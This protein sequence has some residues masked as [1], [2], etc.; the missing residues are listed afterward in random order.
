MCIFRCVYDDRIIT[1]LSK[2][3]GRK[4]MLSPFAIVRIIVSLSDDV[5]DDLATLVYNTMR[6][7]N[8]LW[9]INIRFSLLSHFAQQDKDFTSKTWAGL[10]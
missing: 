1:S 7:Y 3:I 9:I 8:N 6:S 10:I 4:N 5:T 2:F